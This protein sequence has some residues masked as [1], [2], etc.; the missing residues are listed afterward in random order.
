MGRGLMVICSLP[1]TTFSVAGGVSIS[2]VVSVIS[3]V[4][5]PQEARDSASRKERKTAVN[6]REIF[7]TAPPEI[8][9][10]PRKQIKFSS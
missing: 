4:L 1:S 8:F 9:G 10:N 3:S 7:I 2:S 5:C 6:L